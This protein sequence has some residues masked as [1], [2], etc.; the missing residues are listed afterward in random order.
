MM[1]FL[2]INFHHVVAEVLQAA[3]PLVAHLASQNR[4]YMV[5]R[6]GRRFRIFPRGYLVVADHL[7]VV[8]RLLHMLCE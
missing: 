5:L 7:F 4:V 8:L 3:E 2:S 1:F 6:A